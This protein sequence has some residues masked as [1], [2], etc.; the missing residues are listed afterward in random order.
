MSPAI[1]LKKH[2]PEKSFDYCLDLLQRY[3]FK[4]KLKKSRQTKAGDFCAHH[5]NSPVITLNDDLNPYL[6][7]TTFVHEFSHHA[8]HLVYG[9]KPLAHGK[10]WKL[11][12]KTF[13]QPLM[14]LNVFP[15]D[16]QI[17]LTLYLKDPMASS[18]SD[19]GLTR[20]FRR[21]DLIQAE[22]IPLSQ[23]NEGPH[24]C[25]INLDGSFAV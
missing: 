12:F 6:F 19:A 15:Y 18:F 1:I 3:P 2:L 24:D 9:R 17:A 14:E 4:L 23:L 22:G 13:I 7:L 21:Y 25:N 20:I 10:E 11:A 8:V 16:L 5:G